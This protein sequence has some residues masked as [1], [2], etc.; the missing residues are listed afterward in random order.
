MKNTLKL[1][2]VATS[3]ILSTCISVQ[4]EETELDRVAAIVN[5]GVVLESEVKSLI[6]NIKQQSKKNDQSLP[7]DRA[8]RTQVM[9][10]LIND[11]LLLQIGERMGVQVSDAQL[12]DTLTNIAKDSDMTLEQLR[13]SLVAEAI[14]YEKYRENI[15]T[16]LISGEDDLPEGFEHW[17]V[18]FNAQNDFPD[19][20]QVEYAYSLMAKSAGIDMPETRLFKVESGK[21]YF[22]IK[23]FDRLNN[24][25]FHVHTFGN[26]IHSN[27]RRPECDYETFLKVILDLTKNHQDLER[28]FKQ[29]VFN[30]MANNRDDH[31]KNFAFMI[32]QEQEW[33][34][35]P[36]YDLM[37]SN[38][39][40]GEH[41][42]SL[43]GEGLDPG[44]KEI[45]VLGQKLGLSSKIVLSN[46]E[47]VRAAVEKW[48]EFARIAGVTEKT[49][50][51]IQQKIKKKIEKS[52]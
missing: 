51:I 35:T 44:K 50:D 26:L 28:G 40:Y 20:G 27:F 25:R 46:I 36:A 1:L 34:L 22:G 11:S 47:Q 6:S 52:S 31:V 17:I 23:R 14:D 49:K 10:K 7:S 12:D 48:E 13:K 37:Y 39:P 15:R 45:Y 30:V 19:S 32:T 42:M 8:L 33:A 5:S 41:S 24:R 2:A 16:E 3:F 21:S 38:G 9:D 4:A 43:N 18:K 29:M